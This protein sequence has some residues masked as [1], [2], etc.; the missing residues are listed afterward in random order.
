MPFRMADFIRHRHDVDPGGQP[1][2]GMPDAAVHR[3]WTQWK[4]ARPDVFGHAAGNTIWHD[5]GQRERQIPDLF[6]GQAERGGDRGGAQPQAAHVR[7]GCQPRQ[8]DLHGRADEHR[9]PVGVDEDV[10][11]RVGHHPLHPACRART[12]CDSSEC[13]RAS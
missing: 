7:A 4:P 1:P 6:A 13:H 5:R 8:R 12:Y 10:R 9:P 11:A 2:H 3:L